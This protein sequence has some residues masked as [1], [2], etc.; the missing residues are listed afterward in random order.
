MLRLDIFDA[1][2][3]A[4]GAPRA[5]RGGRATSTVNTTG[6]IQFYSYDVSIATGSAHDSASAIDSW[7]FDY[8]SYGIFYIDNTFY[9]YLY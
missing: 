5:C 8:Y 7:S 2:P 4:D 1:S 9:A 3:A 6:Y